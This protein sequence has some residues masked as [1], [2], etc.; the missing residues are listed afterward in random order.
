M[1]AHGLA[2]TVGAP[3]L[4]CGVTSQ[5]A[6]DLSPEAVLKTSNYHV[7]LDAGDCNVATCLLPALNT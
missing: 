4:L 3:E 1:S 6:H 5:P 7:Q 2:H